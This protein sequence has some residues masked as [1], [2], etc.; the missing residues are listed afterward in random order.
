MIRKPTE[1]TVFLTTGSLG[2]LNDG[3]AE[4]DIAMGNF[5]RL[6]I[7]VELVIFSLGDNTCQ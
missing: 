5:T 7:L 4:V 6:D 3:V 2:T 1:E